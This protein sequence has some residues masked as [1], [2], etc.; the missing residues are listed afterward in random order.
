MRKIFLT[1][2][3]IFSAVQFLSA[4]DKKPA[5]LVER[6]LHN[7]YYIGIASASKI[8][9]A[10][11]YHK[12]AKDEALQD[13]S[14][15][16]QVKISGEFMRTLSEQGGAVEENIR[17]LVQSKTRANL[18]GYDLVDSWENDTEYWVFYRLSKDLHKK[19]KEQRLQKAQ[20]LAFDLYLKG[21]QSEQKRHLT[22]ALR[23]Y[24][25]AL[26]M[27]EEFFGEALQIK[28]QGEDIYLQNAIY[29]SLQSGLS[30]IQL[31]ALNP[32][33]EAKSGLALTKPLQI[34]VSCE[35]NKQAFAVANLPVH[36]SFIKGGGQLLQ[37]VSSDRQ[38]IAS[39]QISK[40][41]ATDKIQIVKAV[42]NLNNLAG[43][44]GSPLL[45]ALLTTLTLPET[46]FILTVS[47]LTAYIESTEI[48][49]GQK[50]D[51][52][53][54]EPVLK[55]TL[56]EEGFSFTQDISQADLMIKIEARAR[57][58]SKVYNLFTSFADVNLS[59]TDLTT[60][61][62]IYKNAFKAKG[63]QLD[64]KK[65]GLKALE[66]AGKKLKDFSPEITKKVLK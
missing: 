21:K 66:E 9:H 49:L 14:S 16:I 17:S 33:V 11:D 63:V 3:L 29:T 19:L 22:S 51:I 23:Y 58:G 45:K 35:Q 6:P 4:D 28:Y 25:Q 1:T 50:L 5:W 60:G 48:C 15:E 36:F 57:E 52:L 34:K 44:Q 37:E 61:E 41:E 47:G 18:E 43:R 26:N 7:A 55:E 12:V 42:L 27:L 46:R 56:A 38:G 10:K 24:I 32:K 31:Q 59:I 40:I 2:L 64:F 39:A 65:A 13:L 62:E 54:V 20:H 53:K 30:C 8:E